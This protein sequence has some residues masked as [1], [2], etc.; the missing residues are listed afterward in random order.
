MCSSCGSSSG[1]VGGSQAVLVALLQLLI[2]GG[3]RVCVDAAVSRKDH[4]FL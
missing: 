4:V 3:V 2:A 1:A